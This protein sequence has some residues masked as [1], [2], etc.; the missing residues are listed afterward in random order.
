MITCF[1]Q[2][3]QQRL[4]NFSVR[5]L[6]SL[7]ELPT[8]VPR[9]LATLIGLS[10]SYMDSS[11]TQNLWIKEMTLLLQKSATVQHYLE[12]FIFNKD[13]HLLQ[14]LQNFS[15]FHDG[16]FVLPP[17]IEQ[18][19]PAAQQFGQYTLENP[20]TTAH[21]DM[22]NRQRQLL[23]QLPNSPRILPLLC[24]VAVQIRALPLLLDALQTVSSE[25][26]ASLVGLERD[27][28]S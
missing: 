28:D 12:S 1:S 13:S 9:S 4:N 8:L 24:L 27:A 5:L 17:L 6:V 7:M 21:R 23:A 18:K 26:R 3:A 14:T 2:D 16:I 15:T 22:S 20:E 10:R 11:M 25:E 19:V